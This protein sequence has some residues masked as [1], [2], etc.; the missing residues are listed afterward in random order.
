MILVK[1]FKVFHLFMVGQIGQENVFDGILEKIKSFLDYETETLKREKILI[2][3]KALVLLV[4]SH[5][6]LMQKSGKKSAWHYSKKKTTFLDNKNQNRTIKLNLLKWLLGS[7]LSQKPE[8]K[9]VEKLG[10]FER[11]W[12][13]VLLNNFSFSLFFFYYFRQNRPRKSVGR[14]S[15]KKKNLSR[16]W[17]QEVK[18]VKRNWGF[19]K[20]LVNGFAQKLATFPS[21]CIR[22]K[23]LGKFVLK[24]RL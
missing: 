11:G 8:D 9:D 21:F 13:L 15:T 6:F 3:P 18:K 22:K 7:N 2:F 19:P 4:F 5:V 10:F 1:N 23:R 14:C 16:L 20:K 12:S 24:S 17:K